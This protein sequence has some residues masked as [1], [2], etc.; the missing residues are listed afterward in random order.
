MKW[1]VRNTSLCFMQI[2]IKKQGKNE[3]FKDNLVQTISI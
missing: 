1:T 3:M 2:V